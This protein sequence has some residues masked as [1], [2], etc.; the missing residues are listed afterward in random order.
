MLGSFVL[1]DG[2]TLRKELELKGEIS[3]WDIL[4]TYL[5]IYRFPLF[6]DKKYSS[7]NNKL[8]SYFRLFKGVLGNFKDK[9]QVL[10]YFSF[11][12]KS[13]F[14]IDLTCEKKIR[15]ILFLGFKDVYFRDV[16]SPI[17]KELNKS[18]ELITYVINQKLSN[19]PNSLK[20]YSILNILEK[21]DF[22]FIKKLLKEN[23]KLKSKLLSK[24]FINQI[25]HYKNFK[26]DKTILKNE[27]SWI[28]YREIPRLAPFISV[29]RRLIFNDTPSILVT[30]DDADQKCRAFSLY[31]KKKN[32]ETLL[33]QQGLVRKGYPEWIN[34]SCSKI[35]CMGNYSKK[36]IA[37]QGVSKEKIILTGSPEIDKYIKKN[38]KGYNLFSPSKNI[39]KPRVLFASQPYVHGAYFSKNKRIK[40]ISEIYSALS[41][42]SKIADIVIKPH[43]NDKLHE[44]KNIKNF[45]ENFFLITNE[46]PIYDL[47]KEC[48]VFVT[49]F[50]TSAFHSMC[51]GKPVILVDIGK[52]ITHSEYRNSDCIWAAN[53]RGNL[54]KML[55][56]LLTFNIS[57]HD[58][59]KKNQARKKFISDRCFSDDGKSIIRISKLIISIIKSNR[60]N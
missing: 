5:I 34:F 30:A 40:C 16:L 49:M 17:Q 28:L 3:I 22:Y 58:L 41:K 52:T 2:K 20:H 38:I 13:N 27:L 10:I 25:S 43:P 1:K 23:D 26:I 54:E 19:I 15:K 36:I 9:L 45:S 50:S 44:I 51:A 4:A 33:V 11:K 18:E 53:T 14:S 29:A 57:K 7:L 24:E 37:S 8:I 35:A 32:I 56:D 39:G 46:F 47:I 55:N 48:D 31:A 60:H 6:F 59:K 21:E 42:I 12:K